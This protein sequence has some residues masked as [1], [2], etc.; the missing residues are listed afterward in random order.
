VMILG[1]TCTRGCRFCAV[2]TGNPRGGVDPRE[3]EHVARA[4]TELGLKYAVLTMVDRDDLLDGGAEQMALTVS[5]IKRRAP[6]L[7][8]EALVGDFRGRTESIET[9]LAARPDVF[10]HNLEVTRALTPTIRDARCSYDRSLE[11]LRYAKEHSGGRLTKSSLM[12]GLGETD[13]DV[14]AALADLR[15][16]GVDVATVGQYLRPSDK[17]APVERYV[18]PEQFRVYEREGLALGF[19]FVA[20]GPLV[21]SSYHAAEAFVAA[22]VT[23][24][25]D[26]SRGAIEHDGHDAPRRDRP[27]VQ[28]SEVPVSAA[29]YAAVASP[30]LIPA[31]ALV[32]R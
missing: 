21:R 10:A 7:L 19:Q 6:A 32:R 9:V 8:V 11:V 4:L 31:A 15:G 29:L 25:G 22:T 20:S 17:H 27:V 23:G 18:S 28:P 26:G 14:L 16:A 24:T 12:V 30:Q 3:P 2:A 1:D 13:D 5:A